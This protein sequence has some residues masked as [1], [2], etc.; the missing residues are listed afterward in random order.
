[1]SSNR[2]EM[3]RLSAGKYPQLNLRK[4]YR[5]QAVIS[6]NYYIGMGGLL[7]SPDIVTFPI[8]DMCYPSCPRERSSL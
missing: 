1:M 3:N 4:E 5:I 7:S 8:Y 6:T 2:V